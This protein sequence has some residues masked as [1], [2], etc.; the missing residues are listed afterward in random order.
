MSSMGDGISIQDPA[1]LITYQNQALKNLIG[2]HVGE[3]CYAAYEHQDHICEGCPVEKAYNDGGIHQAERTVIIGKETRYRQVT[4]S[5]LRDFQGNIVSV[6]EVIR[7]VTEQ[8]K[9]ESQLLHAQKMEAVGTLAG[10]IAHDF[11]NILNVIMGYSNMVEDTLAA[12]SP[13]RE[14]MHEVLVAADRAA[15][16]TKRLLLFSRKEPA[17]V[18]PTN[19]NELILGLQKMLVRVIRE[20]IEFHLDLTDTP[21]IV[22]AD[23]GQIEQVL[24]NLASNAKDV[25]QEGGRLLITTGLE[26]IDEAYVAAYRYGRPGRYALITVSDTGQGMDKETQQKIFEPFFT[27][28]GVGKGTGLGLAISYG[29]I[30]QHNGY[31]KVYSEPGE[32]TVFKIFLPLCDEAA[33]D[34][35]PEGVEPVKGGHETILVA[36]DDAALRE[37]SRRILEAFGYRV[38]TAADGEEAIAK[39]LENRERINLVLLDMIM[40][41][42][43]G[44]EVGEAIR[45]VSPKIRILFASGYTSE[46]IS[47]KELLEGSFD[48]I[49]KPYQSKSLL[50]KVREVLDK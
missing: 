1:Y 34:E 24:I 29:I 18:K 39:F 48:F 37:L 47:N 35:K 20:S 8:K 31:I 40:P 4:A 14:D 21:L 13:A 46:I 36:E 22:S 41:K 16:L 6:I 9:L 7:D 44:K 27:T 3:H 32:G 15:D 23:T 10:G 5:P 19:I 33:L 26:E 38:I 28:K 25:M 2:D 45:T 12:D 43:N 11:N 42:K 30:K 17:D 50:L 49:Q